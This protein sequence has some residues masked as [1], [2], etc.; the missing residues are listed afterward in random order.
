MSPG[1]R[2]TTSNDRARGIGP[3]SEPSRIWQTRF[4]LAIGQS[5]TSGFTKPEMRA[6]EAAPRLGEIY[7]EQSLALR[8]GA[9]AEESSSSGPQRVA[10]T[11]GMEGGIE[12]S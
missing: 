11:T 1:F 2:M 9:Q 8:G 10:G 12:E 3:R 6:P 4:R 5:L 7:A